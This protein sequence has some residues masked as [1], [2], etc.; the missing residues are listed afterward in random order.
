MSELS[1]LICEKC[2]IQTSGKLIFRK[3][4]WNDRHYIS[5]GCGYKEFDFT[6]CPETSVNILPDYKY[7]EEMGW[8]YPYKQIEEIKK[9]YD[10][11]GYDFVEFRTKTIDFESPENFMKLFKLITTIENFDIR[12]GNFMIPYIPSYRQITILK[13]DVGEYSSENTDPIKAFLTCVFKCISND[14]DTADY[15]RETEW[16]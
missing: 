13:T 8:Q 12:T 11:N 4:N 9:I 3:R 7:K 5:A 10:K 16:E 2:K 14:K 1:K 6:S 15:I